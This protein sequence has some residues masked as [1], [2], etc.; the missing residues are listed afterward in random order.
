MKYYAVKKGVTPGIYTSWEEAS[1]NVVGFNGASYKSFSSLDDAR[2]FLNDEDTS[3]NHNDKP[4]AYI[5]GSFDVTTG[6]YSFGA[7][8]I[9]EGKEYRFSKKYDADEYS[10][11]RNVAGEIKGAGFIINYCVNHNITALDLYYDYVGIE[12]WYK[13]IWKA[14]KPISIKYAM[15]ASSVKDKI[16]VNFIK[17][18]SH[19]NV[20]YNEMVDKLAKEALGIS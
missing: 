4:F 6:N 5:D 8:L 17:V 10:V 12:N 14:S 20:Y 13:G 9:I 3:L 15:F 1:K 19:T 11:H 2:A 18:K 7:V 16:D